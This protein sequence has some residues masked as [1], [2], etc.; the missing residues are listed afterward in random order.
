MYSLKEFTL[1]E[2]L[3]RS[4]KAYGNRP[5]LRLVSGEGYSYARFL[6][7]CESISAHL[8]DNGVGK[9]D[10]VALVSENSP[11]W[12]A[13]YFAI[14]G[15][16]AVVVPVLT[17]FKAA[18]VAHIIGHSECKAA[19]VSGKLEEKVSDAPA[20]TVVF[21]MGG[22]EPL[23]GAKAAPFVPGARFDHAALEIGADDDAAIIYTSG[24]TGHSKGVVLSNRA[25]AFDA[26]ACRARM[27]L[28][29]GDRLLSILPLGHTYECTV[30]FVYPI[31]Q[32]C[33]I[34]YLDRPSSPSVLSSAMAAVHPTIMLSVPLVIEKTVRAKIIP[35]LARM[36]AASNPFL[37][38]L[39]LRVAGRKLRRA[40]GGRLRWF[41]IGGA[42]LAA[43]IE[44]LLLGMKFPFS[45]G[46]GLTETA[47]L[48][49]GN[50][51]RKTRA[52]SSGFPVDG[53]ELRIADPKPDTGEG[54]V[55]VRGPNVMKGYYKDPERTKEA[56]TPDGWFRTGD[57]G[58]LSRDGRLAIRGR[59]KNMILGPSGENVYPEEIETIINAFDAVQESLVYGE[60]DGTITAL[61]SVKPEF[62][63]TFRGELSE[64]ADRVGDAL[65]NFLETL[66][67]QANSKLAAFSRVGRVVFQEEPF[68]KT[69]TLKIKRF[70]YPKESPRKAPGASDADG[71]RGNAPLVRETGVAGS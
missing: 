53:M 52:G 15:M 28:V 58:C 71:A 10:R 25:I 39:I 2:I 21:R 1:R 65:G 14:A 38:P 46:Y 35:E 27:L 17:D 32:G 66:R 7:R 33:S 30:G 67:K 5:A 42:A 63:E 34:S 12:G 51:P 41:G 20:S 31:M 69:P 9:G 44:K 40:F 56:F 55:Q 57:L 37:R 8:R 43:D 50:P 23:R 11:E 68:E 64:G 19:F 4:A 47:P 59:L 16:G 26:Q 29:R 61:V 54:E 45:V 70:L 13:A 49:S 62:L 36:K 18:Q 3:L 48:I 60:K 24:T 22:F 6:A